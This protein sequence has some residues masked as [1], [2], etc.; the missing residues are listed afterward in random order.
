MKSNKLNVLFFIAIAIGLGFACGRNSG[1]QEDVS[2]RLPRHL[3]SYE[4]KGIRFAYYL[5]PKD[6]NTEGLTKVANSIHK[7]KPDSNLILVD[8]DSKLENYIRYAKSI[9]SGGEPTE[10]PSEWADKHIIANV[11]KYLNGRWVLCK[12]N[13]YEEIAELEAGDQ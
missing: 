12:G 9:S 8:D 1:D 10:L 6:L 5:I 4:I 13:G 11:Q 7:E 2:K 3:D